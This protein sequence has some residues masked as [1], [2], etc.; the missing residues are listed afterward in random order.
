MPKFRH[1]TEFIIFNFD[2]VKSVKKFGQLITTIS[3]KWKMSISIKWNSIKWSFAQNFTFGYDND[4]FYL[5]AGRWDCKKQSIQVRKNLVPRVFIKNHL[6]ELWSLFSLNFNTTPYFYLLA[7]RWDCKK[8]ILCTG[9][10]SKIH[11]TLIY[12]YKLLSLFSLNLNQ[13]PFGYFVWNYV[14]KLN[15]N[16]HN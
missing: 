5:L 3:I 4:Y 1:L 7:G 9:Y 14:Y 12:I 2:Q 16:R 6:T 10:S 15:Y 11:Y 13:T 8:Q